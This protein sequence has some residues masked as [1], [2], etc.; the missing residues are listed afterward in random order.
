MGLLALVYGIIQGGEAGWSSAEILGAFAVA[1]V[2]LSAFAVV[3]TRVEEPT[4]PLRFFRQRDFAGG[5]VII[6]LVFFSVS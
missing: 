5:V 4:L 1:G 2:A 3:E 6:G